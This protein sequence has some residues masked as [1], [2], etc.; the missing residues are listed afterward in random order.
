MGGSKE[1]TENPN[2]GFRCGR[3]TQ[4]GETNTIGQG[5]TN[6]KYTMSVKAVENY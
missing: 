5:L 1:I 3:K 4:T 6:E 2:S